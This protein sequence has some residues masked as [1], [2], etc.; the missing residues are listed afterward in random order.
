M[1]DELVL[2]NLEIRGFRCFRKLEIERLGRVNLIVGR[3]N[4]GKSSL[5]DALRLY[6]NP[7]PRVLLELL[8][9]RDEFD[10]PQGHRTNGLHAPPVPI[11]PLFHSRVATP[12]R[13]PL[14]WIGPI[15]EPGRILQIE[16]T[17]PERDGS[18]PR[19][20]AVESANGL[21]VLRRTIGDSRPPKY[22]P[23]ADLPRLARDEHIA[24]RETEDFD[25]VTVP[26]VCI[27]SKGLDPRRIVE[28]W[29]R[30]NL[31]ESHA[32]VTDSLR[33]IEPRIVQSSANL[34]SP[35]KLVPIVRLRGNPEPVVL[36]SLGEGMV[37]LFQ[38]GLA[39]ANAAQVG[40]SSFL[41]V[42]EIE[43]GLHYSVH[44]DLWRFVFRSARELNVQVFATTHSWDCIEAFQKAASEDE[45][46][47]G[48]LIRLGWKREDVVATN[49]DE[50]DLC[51]VTRDHIEVR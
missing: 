35:E 40:L 34:L 25:A 7:S 21:S 51:V 47:D 33:L 20:S 6:A 18:Q 12:D 37:H 14:I 45:S 17:Q 27:G 32:I 1:A 30:V 38:L 46:S 44:E 36:R 8:A 41:L 29:H 49:Y 5:L 13:T 3:N 42:D 9:A 39:L 31:T 11:G 26:H 16:L 23:V 2:P 43:N 28:S 48:Y 19:G 24:T 10:Q 15:G 4:V 50:D 22:L